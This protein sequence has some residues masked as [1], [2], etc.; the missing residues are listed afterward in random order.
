M[1][2]DFSVKPDGT[3]FYLTLHNLCSRKHTVIGVL[4]L[5]NLDI[6]LYH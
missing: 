1:C 6:L 3:F 5:L 2:G 4:Y